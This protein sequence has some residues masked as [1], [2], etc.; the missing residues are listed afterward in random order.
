MK[1]LVLHP[2]TQHSRQ[3]ALALQELGRLECLVTGLFDF[4]DG[5]MRKLID[6][7]PGR[8][9]VLLRKE[10]WR[11]SS[12]GLDPDKVRAFPGYELPERLAYR[13]GAIPLGRRLD[14][15]LN[16][17]FGKRVAALAWREG[18]FALWGYD[19]SAFA[20]F[21]DPRTEH[22]PKILDR[23][24]ADGR[25]WNEELERIADTHGDW[26]VGGTPG[27]DEQRIARNDIEYR[28][29]DRI[30]CGSPFVMQSVARYS[31]VPG[32]EKK[33]VLLP[34]CYD[35]DLFSGAPRPQFVPSDEPVRFLFVGQISARKGIQ[36]LLEAFSSLPTGSATL[37]L[38]GP[39]MVPEKQISP[40]RDRVDFLGALPRTD[41]P[42]LMQR[43]HA[44]VFPSHFEG[45]AIALI[46]AMASGLAIVQTEAAGLGASNR[47]G[48]V[49]PRPDAGDVAEAMMALV[50]DRE[51][52]QAMRLAAMEDAEDRD[53]SA[54]R[55][56]IGQLLGG[57]DL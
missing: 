5:A 48:F 28:L 25:Y 6:R 8:L 49:L 33:L 30:V 27:W 23:T 52:L 53:F 29:A 31:P 14:A 24:I 55:D 12:P 21:A 47:S 7:L 34:Y 43:H 20:A 11:F 40:Y 22:C 37:T 44:F 45:S 57:M 13:A 41:I 15:V 51:R 17:R 35:A 1:T 38:A 10:L 36:H 19:N 3:T 4:P 26:L 54:Y 56:R 39:I 46:E 9:A 42:A 2:G 16:L 18:P 50:D 32:L